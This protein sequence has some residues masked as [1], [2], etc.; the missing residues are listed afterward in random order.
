M[1]KSKAAQQA[2]D[3][4]ADRDAK[5]RIS[6]QRTFEEAHAVLALLKEAADHAPHL[7]PQ[8]TAKTL[9]VTA[10]MLSDQLKRIDELTGGQE[11]L[12]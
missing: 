1:R 3:E 10:R 4:K 5:A 8:M 7:W 6:L 2:A 12:S 11:V 9:S